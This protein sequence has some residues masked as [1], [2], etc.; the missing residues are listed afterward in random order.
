MAHVAEWKKE[1]VLE[2]K[3]LIDKYVMAQTGI[4]IDNISEIQNLGF[5]GAVVCSDVWNRFNI[6]NGL[7]FK[8]VIKHFHR[9]RKA[10]E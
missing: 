7:D 4:N 2:L 6:H 5:G 9:L 10:A 3:G 1:E 8:D